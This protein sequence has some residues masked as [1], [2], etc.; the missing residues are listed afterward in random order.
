MALSFST[1][2]PGGAQTQ[3][4]YS[5][6]LRYFC[7][8]M[9]MTKKEFFFTLFLP[10]VVISSSLGYSDPPSTIIKDLRGDWQYFESGRYHPFSNQKV[11]AVY[12]NIEAT[13]YKGY[14]FSITDEKPFTVFID[15]KLIA[16]REGGHYILNLDSLSRLYSSSLFV[17]IYQ[18]SG[19]GAIRTTIETP[20]SVEQPFLNELRGQSY[21]LNF[22]ILAAL[23][24]FAYFIALL[25]ANPKLTLDY[26]NIAKIFSVQE[27]EDD[28]LNSRVTASVNLLFYL[29]GSLFA[30]LTLLV[31]FHSGE[32]LIPVASYF[33]INSLAG[34]F[35]QWIKLSALISALLFVKLLLIYFISF[36]FHLKD[37]PSVHFFN[38]MRV[39][40]LIFSIVAI[41]CTLYFMIHGQR[42]TFYL[43]L[44]WMS[45]I[46]FILGDL[47]IY[48]KLLVKASFRGFHLFSYLCI[49]EIIPLVILIRILLY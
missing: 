42:P 19:I 41:G 31:I 12:F 32:S 47:M 29:F 46:I 40:L 17:G 36:I 8:C 49:T 48:F 4:V 2:N 9:L 27:R 16:G 22:S 25:H 11:R 38:Y 35:L 14:S 26:F 43:G 15:N 10:F 28:L 13:K 23:F 45:V 1:V 21:F 18:R 34:G 7:C 44:L 30:A 3:F 5:L 24:L 33:K 39:L 6:R 20:I 37:T